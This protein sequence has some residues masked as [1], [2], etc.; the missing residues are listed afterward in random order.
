MISET[1]QVS[2]SC[3][4]TGDNR[5]RITTDTDT[6]RLAASLQ[7]TGLINPPVLLETDSGFRIV[8][9]FRRVAA[10]RQ[11]AWSKLHARILPDAT[12]PLHCVRLAVTD[13]AFQRSLNPLETS[14]GLALLS[15]FYPDPASLA[16]AAAPLGLPGNASLIRKLL[17]LCR[18]HPDLQDGI[19]TE[20]IALP[21]AL[22]LDTFSPDE[23][24]A[25][26]GLLR[27]L[28]LSLSKQREIVG[29]VKEIAL[30]E[31]LPVHRVLDASPIRE[32]MADPD[33]DRN[34]K[35]ARIRSYL[36]RRRFPAITEKEER[37]ASLVRQLK[38]EPGVHLTP[39][40]HFEGPAY[41][42][43]LQFRN[44]AELAARRDALDRLLQATVLR[45]I[46]D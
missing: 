11:L 25:L 21:V 13:N 26:A 2:V 16:E 23:G 39:P 7:T 43:T 33:P 35:A 18:F 15:E 42:L 14:R 17:P 34:R 27:S 10:C 36:R 9:G 20:H 38:L 40:P 41:T 37:Y 12:D 19:L 30:R 44:H 22:E 5:F 45:E 8:C 31:E 29:L 24:L 4:D 28:N 6:T 1:R 3:I 46:L 32:T